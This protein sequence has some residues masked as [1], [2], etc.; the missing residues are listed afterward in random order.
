MAPKGVEKPCDARLF[1]ALSLVTQ[2]S[3]SSR[4]SQRTRIGWMRILNHIGRLGRMGK[5]GNF[6][7]FMVVSFLI[8]DCVGEDRR[9]KGEERW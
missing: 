2:R 6:G 9:E 4:S 1:F 3:Q 5:M 8:N 7:V